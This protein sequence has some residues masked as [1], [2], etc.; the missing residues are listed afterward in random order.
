MTKE[1]KVYAAEFKMQMVK[2]FLES[3]KTQREFCREHDICFNTFYSWLIKYKSSLPSNNLI[4][5]T[6]PVKE[7][8]NDRP[9]PINN[10]STFTVEINKIKFVFKLDDLKSVIEAFK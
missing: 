9:A 10:P 2:D 1:H 8:I 7:I 5:V 3:N 4:E 6:E